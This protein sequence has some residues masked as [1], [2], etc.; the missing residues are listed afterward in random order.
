MG[1][2][3][4]RVEPQDTPFSEWH[5]FPPTQA[6][7]CQPRARSLDPYPP[8]PPLA[9]P[10]RDSPQERFDVRRRRCSPRGAQPCGQRSPESESARPRGGGRGQRRA[11][12]PQPWDEQQVPGQVD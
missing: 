9:S 12:Q 11:R 2:Y 5:G 10:R 1:R 7:G 8:T 6:E 3:S 4:P